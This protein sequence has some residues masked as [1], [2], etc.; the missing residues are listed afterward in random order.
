MVA[1]ERENAG[2]SVLRL[3]RQQHRRHTRTQKRN[4]SSAT[5][6]AGW[7]AKKRHTRVRKPECLTYAMG[8]SAGSPLAPKDKPN[9]ELPR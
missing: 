2:L 3:K 9:S 5:R 7:R 1:I 6:E 8:W 4:R